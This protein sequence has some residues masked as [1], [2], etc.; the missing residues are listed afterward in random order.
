MPRGRFDDKTALVTGA[1]SGIGRATALG[2][3]ARGARLFLGDVDSAGLEE[4][5][6][7]ARNSSVQVTT[8]V[9]DVSSRAAMRD[10]ATAVH[11]EVPA[12]D[13]LVNNAGVGIGGGFLDTSLEDWDWVVSI[14]LWGVIHGCHFFL[15]NMVKRGE[16]GHVVNVASAAGFYAPGD[17]A[18]YG[19]TKYAVFGL[20]E[21]LRDELEPKGIHVSTICPGIIN[22]KITS[23]SRLRGKMAPSREDLVRV[24]RKRNYGPEK[25]AER[26]LAAI[27]KNAG[28]VPVTPEAWAI[29]LMKRAFPETTPRL[30]RRLNERMRRSR[31]R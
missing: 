28:I 24:Y 23:T 31:E 3:A 5:A 30:L 6:E 1:G 4:T 20:S 22:T 2:L 21:A 19:T 29:Y 9:V 8:R 27:E 26:I 16:G 11:A 18:A 14:N 10:W 17:L 15:P 13:V 7:Q 25:V 12:L